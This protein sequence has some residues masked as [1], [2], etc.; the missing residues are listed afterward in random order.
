MLWIFHRIPRFMK[1]REGCL[2]RCSQSRRPAFCRQLEWPQRPFQPPVP[3]T[4]SG[5]EWWN[6]GIVPVK[7]VERPG[8]VMPAALWIVLLQNFLWMTEDHCI[9]A[10]LVKISILIP[11]TLD[12]I[13]F[14]S[15]YEKLKGNKYSSFFS[16]FLNSS[17]IHQTNLLSWQH[18]RGGSRISP[19]W[20]RQPS[21][22]GVQTYDFA[23]FSQ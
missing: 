3:L 20:G 10:C 7:P 21:R 1:A 13:E 17:R 4:A 9:P 19:R 18:V 5:T 15:K 8:T 16:A 14:T 11:F 22:V 6:D 2:K 12:L 23:K